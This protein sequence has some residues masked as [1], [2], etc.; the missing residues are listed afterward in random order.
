MKLFFFILYKALKDCYILQH[1]KQPFAF[2]TKG[3]LVWVLFFACSFSTQFFCVRSQQRCFTATTTNPFMV[4]LGLKHGCAKTKDAPP[5]PTMCVPLGNVLHKAPASLH[6]AMRALGKTT[7][8]LALF[9]TRVAYAK[10]PQPNSLF[11]AKTANAQKARC[12]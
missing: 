6:G 12:V 11:A 9:A 10:W 4:P 8:V 5:L 7:V 2:C 3:H 1:R